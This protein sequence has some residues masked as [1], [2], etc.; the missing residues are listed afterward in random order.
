MLEKTQK[1][2]SITILVITLLLIIIWG[3]YLLYAYYASPKI[4][5]F[6]IIYPTPDPDSG[7]VPPPNAKNFIEPL[8]ATGQA[9]KDKLIKD[10]LAKINN[11]IPVNNPYKTKF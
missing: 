11:N 2:I 5:P 1:N 8:T 9:T 3:I 7:L 6:E 4:W 10:A